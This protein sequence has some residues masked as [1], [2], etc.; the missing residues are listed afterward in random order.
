MDLKKIIRERARRAAVN[1]ALRE[2]ERYAGAMDKEPE[3]TINLL[4]S[5][6]TVN[7]KAAKRKGVELAAQVL[8]TYQEKV[9]NK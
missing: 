5:G 9:K 1:V 4:N 6:I 7:L 2:L 3:T 8:K